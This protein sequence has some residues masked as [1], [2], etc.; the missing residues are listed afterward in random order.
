MEHVNTLG[1][2]MD[3]IREMDHSVASV[4]R[5]HSSAYCVRH[6]HFYH[7]THQFVPRRYIVVS[8]H[9]LCL[10]SLLFFVVLTV[11]RNQL[12]SLTSSKCASWQPPQHDKGATATATE[13]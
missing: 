9:T 13:Q 12:C 6:Y 5:V 3:S 1:V 4:F 11:N 10:E 2:G 7:R 8:S